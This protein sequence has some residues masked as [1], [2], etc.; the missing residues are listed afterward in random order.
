[1]AEHHVAVAGGH[2]DMDYAE[3]DK[4]YKLFLGM[5]KYGTVAVILAVI[6]LAFVTL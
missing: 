1:M 4:T 2:P 3:H 6:I 5:V